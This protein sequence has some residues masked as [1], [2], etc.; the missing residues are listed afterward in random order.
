MDKELLETSS[1]ILPQILTFIAV[2]AGFWKV[3]KYA[4]ASEVRD[5]LSKHSKETNIR[6][7]HQEKNFNDRID[8]TD[9][10]ID[11]LKNIILMRK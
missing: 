11:D 8:N 10:K 9:N 3:F 2:F 5:L 4:I 1:K 7:E 6:M